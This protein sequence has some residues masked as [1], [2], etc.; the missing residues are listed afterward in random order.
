[1]K[2]SKCLETGLIRNCFIWWCLYS[3][4]LSGVF[5]SSLLIADQPDVWAES[6]V[7]QCAGRQTQVG[8]LSLQVVALIEKYTSQLIFQTKQY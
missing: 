2:Y 7:L 8:D 3:H 5:A 6:Q 4:G 1:M